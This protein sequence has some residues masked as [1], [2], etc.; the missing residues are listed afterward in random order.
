MDMKIYEP[1]PI[2][3]RMVLAHVQMCW[4]FLRSGII[5]GRGDIC[6]INGPLPYGIYPNI[7]IFCMGLMHKFGPGEK[8]EAD[9]DGYRGQWLCLVA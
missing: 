1:K 2:L 4:S 6:W 7:K 5:I 8:M 9:N 3:E